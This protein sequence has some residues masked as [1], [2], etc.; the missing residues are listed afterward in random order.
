MSDIRSVTAFAK[1]LIPASYQSLLNDVQRQQME[2]LWELNQGVTDEE[3]REKLMAFYLQE[4]RTR[5][6]KYEGISESELSQ[7]LYDDI[8]GFSVLT[9]YLQDDNVEGININSWEDIR[10]KYHSGEDKKGE[11]FLSPEHAKIVLDK[12]LRES[13][14][15]IDEAIPTAEASIGSDI[16][17]TGA[18]SPIVSSI[19]VYIRRLRHRN[20]TTDE[21]VK[22]GFAP[23][24]VLRFLHLAARRGVSTLFIG[25]VNTGKTTVLKHV[26]DTLP[27]S[28]QIVTIETGAREMDL[29]KRN[30]NGRIIN[31]VVHMLTRE[32]M[33]DQMNIT[34]EKLV[35]K[36]LRLNPDVVSVAEMRDTEAH[37]AV[38]A[39]NS[40]HTVFSTVH[41]GSVRGAHKRIA[42]LARKKYPTDFHT[43][44]VDAC[45]AFPLG[46]F[47]H[48]T[49][50]NV[51]RVMNI[52]ECYVDGNDE[53]HY[54]TLWDFNVIENSQ[55]SDGTVSVSGEYIQRNAP[56]DN[57]IS[58]MSLFGLTQNELA[59][60]L[61]TT[62]KNDKKEGESR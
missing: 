27:N 31:N 4:I 11:P 8:E 34:Q 23:P 38:E 55:N 3:R 19:A 54:Q 60:F 9:N 59:E 22:N 49:E 45:E 15:T 30:E 50:D 28:T 25:K 61:I 12:L 21:Y 26:L 24:S 6:A 53:I 52:S 1:R 7:R 62:D 2:S 10:I 32:H 42:N 40:G 46:V 16:R 33:D 18:I 41:A 37:A 13:G 47:I 51:R 35:V 58:I 48:T 5:N 36:A 14:I 17:I 43:A 56:S 29:T 39:S 44:M 57:L 20:F